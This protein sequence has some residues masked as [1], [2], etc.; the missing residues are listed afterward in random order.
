MG[1]PHILQVIPLGFQAAQEERSMQA[2]KILSQAGMSM[3][4]IVVYFHQD[5]QVAITL[6][7]K[8]N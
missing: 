2:I 3:G 5:V 8:G 1:F 4:G 6:R 7:K